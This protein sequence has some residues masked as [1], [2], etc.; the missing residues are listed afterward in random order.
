MVAGGGEGRIV[1][2]CLAGE[3]KAH[4]EL[5][6]D[7]PKI[8]STER[9]QCISTMAK[10]GTPSYVELVVCLEMMRDS[11]AHREEERSNNVGSRIEVVRA[12]RL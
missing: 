2:A 1:E 12:G 5:E 7:R 4:K 8:P 10:G 9:S 3:E 11:R 6:K